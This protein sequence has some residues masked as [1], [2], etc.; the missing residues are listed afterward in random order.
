MTTARTS[1][2]LHE[3]LHQ[4]ESADEDCL[5][6]VQESCIEPDRIESILGEILS[7]QDQLAT[8]SHGGVSLSVEMVDEWVFDRNALEFAL[9]PRLREA[10]EKGTAPRS[11]KAADAQRVIDKCLR[12]W[13]HQLQSGDMSHLHSVLFCKRLAC[14]LQLLP[15]KPSTDDRACSEV[16]ELH[17]LKS[18]I[19]IH[20]SMW[21]SLLRIPAGDLFRSTRNKIIHRTRDWYAQ[22]A[23]AAGASLALMEHLRLLVE[24]CKFL[25]ERDSLRL[26]EHL[27]ECL[28][29]DY[30][31]QPIQ[32]IHTLLLQYPATTDHLKQDVTSASVTMAELNQW[33]ADERDCDLLSER[34]DM[35]CADD[36]PDGGAL[37]SAQLRQMKRSGM[38][39]QFAAH[40]RSCELLF[41]PDKRRQRVASET[42]SADEINQ[43]FQQVQQ[44]WSTLNS[45]RVLFSQLHRYREQIRLSCE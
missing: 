31:A 3:L 10:K 2:H 43:Q 29:N 36:D 38:H 4:L 8:F 9:G 35:L 44:A 21:P 1:Q 13:L 25:E 6:R 24:Q 18:R 33:D 22:A 42:A 14:A 28:C 27:D 19:L 41:H 37:A 26:A 11:V 7:C 17:A 45:F 12:K 15:R 20:P 40:Q 39:R 5:Q 30:P 32:L 16:L 34:V 23:R